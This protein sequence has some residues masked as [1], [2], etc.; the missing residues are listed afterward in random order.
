[1][2]MM[3]TKGIAMEITKTHGHAAAVHAAQAAHQAHDARPPQAGHDASASASVHGPAVIL[4]G[5]LAAAAS[6]TAAPSAQVQAN[7]PHDRTQAA[8]RLA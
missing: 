8:G 6:Q 3:T 2:V 5:A 1:M 7:A 4:G